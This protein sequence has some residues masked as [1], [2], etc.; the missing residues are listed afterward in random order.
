[1]K[2]SV[3]IIF[4]IDL[5]AFFC[6]CAIIKEPYLKDKVFAVGGSSTMRRG[7]I[8]QHPIITQEN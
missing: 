8:F 7:V 1:M 4:H 6:S 5:N 2:N 3:K